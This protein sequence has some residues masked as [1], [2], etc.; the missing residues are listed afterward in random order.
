MNGIGTGIPNGKIS[1]AASL[2]KKEIEAEKAIGISLNT[3]SSAV[4]IFDAFA[5][6]NLYICRASRNLNGEKNRRLGMMIVIG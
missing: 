3:P 5:R 6:Y 1:P 4:A 2:D